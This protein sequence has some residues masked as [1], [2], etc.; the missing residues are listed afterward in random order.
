M[1]TASIYTFSTGFSIGGQE[2]AH[3]LVF[4]LMDIFS[5]AFYAA[6]ANRVR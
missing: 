4:R 5:V 2:V 3:F 1:E 6:E